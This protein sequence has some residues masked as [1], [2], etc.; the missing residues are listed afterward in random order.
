MYAIHPKIIEEL[1]EDEFIHIT[2]IAKRYMDRQERV[3]VFPVPE[4]MWL[5][6]GQFNEMETML[7]ELGIKDR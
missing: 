1:N 4:K 7:E 6:M 5:D 3:G 2:D